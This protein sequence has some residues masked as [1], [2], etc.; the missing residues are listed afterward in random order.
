MARE[1]GAEE[2]IGSS[3]SEGIVKGVRIGRVIVLRCC[4]ACHSAGTIESERG[5]YV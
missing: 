2:V 1:E 4:H 3:M 5:G